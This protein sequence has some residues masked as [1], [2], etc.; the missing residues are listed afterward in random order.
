MKRRARSH[1]L[2]TSAEVMRL[3]GI[4]RNT[5]TN[6]IRQGLAFVGPPSKAAVTKRCVRL[7]RGEDLNAFHDKRRAEAKRPSVADQLYCLPCHAH[8]SLKGRE[9]ELESVSGIAGQLFWV[10]PDCRRAAKLSVGPLIIE[11][12]SAHGVRIL[13]RAIPTNR[14]SRSRVDCAQ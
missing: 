4:S 3:Y 10:C 12:L 2:Y 1:M 14:L 8:K 6:W 11:R 13:R 7:F 5:L 9:V